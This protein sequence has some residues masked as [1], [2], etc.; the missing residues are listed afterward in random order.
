MFICLP[1]ER[2]GDGDFEDLLS[3]ISAMKIKRKGKFTSIIHSTLEYM[4]NIC[5]SN[6]RTHQRTK[7]NFSS[8]FVYVNISHLTI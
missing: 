1:C 3:G 7:L 6:P 2:P 4:R 8:I 5:K